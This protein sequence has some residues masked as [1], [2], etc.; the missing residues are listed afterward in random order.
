MKFNKIKD[1]EKH[2]A[3]YENPNKELKQTIKQFVST[4]PND[5]IKWGTDTFKILSKKGIHPISNELY[6]NV[7][8]IELNWERDMLEEFVNLGLNNYRIHEINCRYP[9][10]EFLFKGIKFK[11]H[12]DIS[13]IIPRNYDHI[14][15]CEGP[16]I[17]FTQ[18][19]LDIDSEYNVIPGNIYYNSEGDI[20]NRNYNLNLDTIVYDN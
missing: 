12:E 5:L 3:V 8:N 11:D 6:Y 10:D 16:N 14:D 20:V 2:Y 9:I 4:L 17:C 15:Y 18:F 1:L 19:E 13:R 7:L